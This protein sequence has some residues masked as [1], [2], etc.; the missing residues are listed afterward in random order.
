MNCPKC[1]KDTT[2]LITTEAKRSTRESRGLLWVLMFPVSVVVFVLRIALLPIAYVL[3]FIP[4]FRWFFAWTL[5]R[6]QKYYKRTYWH[7][8][9]C[10]YDWK[11]HFERDAKEA[12]IEA[13]AEAKEQ[14]IEDKVDAKVHD[15]EFK[16]EQKGKIKT[17]KNKA[18]QT[19][20][21]N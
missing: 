10:G 14:K 12:K 6:K 13:K 9:Y 21:G 15:I 2:V 4:V 3:S 20:K 17:A 7:C 8:N 19:K 5:G 16:A 11:P 1:N 18:K